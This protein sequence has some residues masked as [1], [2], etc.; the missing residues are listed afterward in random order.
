MLVTIKND[1][2][3]QP[4]PL[5]Y[6]LSLPTTSDVNA[7][8]K[9]CRNIDDERRKMENLR[10][11]TVAFKKDVD[12]CL[13]K[14]NLELDLALKVRKITEKKLN[15]RKN[16]VKVLKELLYK[17]QKKVVKI[18]KMKVRND[19]SAVKPVFKNCVKSLY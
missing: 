9:F 13:N 2:C 14:A 19:K 3:Q 12:L 5:W 4:T 8:I 10:N 11:R 17:E 6:D 15:K 1:K 7:M 18:R 16:E